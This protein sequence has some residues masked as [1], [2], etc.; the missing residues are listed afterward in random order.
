MTVREI[1]YFFGNDT[2]PKNAE[3]FLFGKRFWFFAQQSVE[4][5]STL[6]FFFFF[7]PL[8]IVVHSTVT[9]HLT[10][11]ISQQ[12]PALCGTANWIL[13]QAVIPA[14][15]WNKKQT[16]KQTCGL[17]HSSTSFYVSVPYVTVFLLVSVWPS[18][19]K[20]K[21]MLLGNSSSDRFQC[22]QV[23]C[24]VRMRHGTARCKTCK[25]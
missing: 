16:A 21:T 15:Q 6:I 22:V 7:W 9:C 2:S 5:D 10:H 19:N 17:S 12:I 25:R 18:K 24:W 4:N 1:I 8:L 20:K 23:H 14:A 3:L 13:L 11:G